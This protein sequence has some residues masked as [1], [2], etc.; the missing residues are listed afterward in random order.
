MGFPLN[1]LNGN[2]A[3]VNG[4]TYTYNSAKTA[5]LRA[6]TTGANLTANSMTLTSNAISISSTSG[7]LIVT[8]GAGIGGNLYVAGSL[9]GNITGNINSTGGSLNASAANFGV[10]TV[11]GNITAGNVNATYFV[12]TQLQGNQP[13]ITTLANIQIYSLGVGTTPS[14][15]QGEIRATNAIT[16]YYSDERLKTRLGNIEN[17]LDKVDQ[18]SGFYHEANDLAVSLGFSK[19]REVGV[20]AQELQAVLPEVV[21]QAPIDERYL[22]VRYERL[23]PLLIQ[24]IKEL[25]QEV[26][27]IKKQLG[28]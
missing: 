25:H 20:S 28:G 21:T 13:N 3:T 12:G 11:T 8:G 16:S 14:Q 26:N 18:I 1:P 2:V 17:A 6:S 10:L 5:W 9:F 15:T 4:I 23:A 24:A 7:A 19:T 22:T 27:A